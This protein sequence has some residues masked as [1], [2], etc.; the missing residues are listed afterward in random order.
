MGDTLQL[1]FL[2]VQHN[3]HPH[4]YG[5]YIYMNIYIYKYIYTHT[6]YA[7]CYMSPQIV[8]IIS[9]PL[10][11]AMRSCRTADFFAADFRGTCRT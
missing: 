10:G 3:Y 11:P 2:I 9:G 5:I 7:T 4:L 6:Y 1:H 8:H